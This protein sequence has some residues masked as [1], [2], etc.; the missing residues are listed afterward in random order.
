MPSGV[1]HAPGTAL[2]I[3]LQEDSDVLA[4][5]QALNAG[6]IISKELLW[7]DVRPIDREEKGERFILELIDWEENGDPYFYE[8]HHLVAAADRGDAS[9]G[10]RG[11]VDL[12]QHA[13][14]SAARR[15]LVD[16]GCSFTSVDRGVYNILVWRGSGTY[17]GLRG[18]GRRAGAGRAARD[19]RSS[20]P[21]RRGP[22]HGREQMLV[23]KFFGPT[24]TRCPDDQA[25]LIRLMVRPP[26]RRPWRR[27]SVGG[28]SG[29]GKIARILAARPRASR[30]GALVAVGSR[31]LDR[32]ARLPTEFGVARHGDYEGVDR[33]TPGSTSSTSP[34]ATPRTGSGP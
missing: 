13:R 19:A 33:V 30:D 7:K 34:P 10:R 11:V 26:G 29:T 14:S 17:G 5:L 27:R 23:V 16:P 9:A 31:D 32:A 12:L 8:N 4:M 6:V 2:T 1:L 25:T 21:G 22:E 20:R 28:S 18:Q 24:S 15:L 3:E